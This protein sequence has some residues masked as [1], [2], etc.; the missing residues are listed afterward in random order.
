MSEQVYNTLEDLQAR[1]N[2]LKADIQENNEK[3]A[4]VWQELVVP[5]KS[6]S[7]GELVANLVSN[8]I[9][10]I[11]GF[12]LVHKLIKNYGFLFSW[13]RKKSKN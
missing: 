3:I 6:N 13:K 12:L 1:K 11:D 5:K 4:A 8:G 9:T 2:E 10:A 7:K